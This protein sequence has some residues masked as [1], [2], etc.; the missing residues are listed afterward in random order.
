LAWLCRPGQH[1]SLIELEYLF[2][3]NKI[4][5]LTR[6][7]FFSRASDLTYILTNQFAVG[8]VQKKL[9]YDGD[10]RRFYKTFFSNSEIGKNFRSLV[11]FQILF[12]D[13]VVSC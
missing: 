6:I 13:F 5:S 9:A 11:G 3:V 7:S 1:E 10:D 12:L 2:T 8:N 4:E